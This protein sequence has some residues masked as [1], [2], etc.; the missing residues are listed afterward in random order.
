MGV[1]NRRDF[2]G[3]LAAC[4]VGMT[5]LSGDT[6]YTAD[7]VGTDEIVLIGASL[8]DGTGAPARAD[9]TLVLANGWIVWA[10]APVH[11]P[12]AGIR[13]IDL[14]GKYV[15]PGL[16]DMH[17]H[18]GADEG[19]I[20][21]LHIA[22]GVTSVREMWGFPQTLA[23]R[24]RI[25][26]GELLGPRMTIASSI[27]DGRPSV[28]APLAT[29]VV[30]AEEART[31][32]RVAAAEGYDFLKVYSYLGPEP[33]WALVDEARKAGLPVAGHHPARVRLS[34]VADAG[35]RSFEHLLG[36][37]TATST[38]EDEILG[39]LNQFPAGP[40]DARSFYT[41]LYRL[42]RQAALRHSPD[43]AAALYDRLARNGCWQSPTLTVNRVY[44]MPAETYA[45]DPRLK[46]VSAS[47]KSEWAATMGGAPT[48]LEEVAQQRE[49]FEFRLAMVG[50]M[51]RA[52]VP[53]LG[54][55]DTANPYV[56]AGF[57]AHDELELLVQAGLS[58]MRALQTMTRDAARFLGLEATMGTIERGKVA[59]LV[60]LDANPLDGIRNTQRIHAVVTRGRI[61]DS[62]QRAQIL[63]DV[64]RAASPLGA[65]EPTVRPAM[66][67]CGCHG[68]AGARTA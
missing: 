20:L 16:W 40:A 59:D 55:S 12:P 44:S 56:F 38:M 49:Y 68:H 23:T 67:A 50:Q 37:P 2:L 48:S 41:L 13:T 46:Y 33:F 14:R 35:M 61:I 9:S 27:I 28:W 31:A 7:T 58:P 63:A 53:I 45:D 1:H 60:V 24:D 62:A 54:G 52:G 30:T 17:T 39:R 34:E 36:M 11:P 18:F 25:D 15:I 19:T 47:T 8:I 43:R 57:A 6:P 64:Q 5:V 32:V 29:Q 10:G 65:G 51:E 42:E 4:G 26:R 66:R 22:N 21:P 3:W